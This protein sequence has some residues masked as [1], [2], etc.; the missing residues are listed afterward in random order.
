VHENSVCQYR[1]KC[2]GAEESIRRLF[3]LSVDVQRESINAEEMAGGGVNPKIK[4][5]ERV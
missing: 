1:E 3:Q 2:R 5:T 4:A